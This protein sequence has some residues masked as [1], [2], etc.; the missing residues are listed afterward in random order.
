MKWNKIYLMFSTVGFSGWFSTS[1]V[2]LILV[3][4]PPSGMKV[5]DSS[6]DGELKKKCYKTTISI[7]KLH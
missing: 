5:E 6:L 2:M 7:L 3:F 1:V 4:G